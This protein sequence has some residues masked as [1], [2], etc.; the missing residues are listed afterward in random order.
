MSENSRPR[1]FL[2]L[3]L[4]VVTLIAGCT[5]VD[6]TTPT[7]VGTTLKEDTK[8]GIEQ[9]KCGDYFDGCGFLATNC[10]TLTASLHDGTGEVKFGDIVEPTRFQVQGI[11]RRWDW[12]LNAEDAYECAFLIS[13]DGTGSYYNFRGSDDGTAKPR[14]LFKCAKR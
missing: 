2:P 4:T 1:R 11:E 8:A 10:I 9:W 13:V 6:G 3:I 7:V 14:D 5:T 12:C